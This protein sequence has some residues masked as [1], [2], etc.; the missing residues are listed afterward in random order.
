MR[1][2]TRTEYAVGLLAALAK[3]QTKQTMKQ[4]T[5]QANVSPKYAETI[6]QELRKAGVVRSTRGRRG[7][8]VLARPASKITVL[9]II[10]AVDGSLM[11]DKDSAN[12]AFARLNKNL[13]LLVRRQLG[14]MPLAALV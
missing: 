1:L 5:E 9:E 7:G 12:K 11:P 3:S 6:L 8:F 13:R 10:E 2:T 14:N 4:M